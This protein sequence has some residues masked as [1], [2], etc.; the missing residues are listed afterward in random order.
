MI[1]ASKI[2]AQVRNLLTLVISVVSSFVAC[3]V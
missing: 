1:K 3:Q 2:L